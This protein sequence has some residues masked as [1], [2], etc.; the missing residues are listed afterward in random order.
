[1]TIES[2]WVN[3]NYESGHHTEESEEEGVD[4]YTMLELQG[5]ASGLA[6]KVGSS[7]ELAT[8]LCSDW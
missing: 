5:G 4:G 1:M 8:L 3:N 2:F 7:S 6:Q